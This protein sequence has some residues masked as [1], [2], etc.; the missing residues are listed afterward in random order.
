MNAPEIRFEEALSRAIHIVDRLDGDTL[1][2]DE[3]LELF[4]EG[5]RLLR[6][7]EERLSRVEERIRVLSEDGRRLDEHPGGL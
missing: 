4:E 2:L 6:V 7:A 3:A 1:E 5:V